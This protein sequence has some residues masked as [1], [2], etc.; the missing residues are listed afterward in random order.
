MTHFAK[1]KQKGLLV[2]TI[3]ENQKDKKKFAA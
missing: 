1:K 3:S 2:K